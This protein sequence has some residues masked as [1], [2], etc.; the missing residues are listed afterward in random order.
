MEAG[1]QC[2]LDWL[3]LIWAGNRA[4]GGGR[5]ANVL[6]GSEAGREGASYRSPRPW[7]VLALSFRSFSLQ[8]PGAL[9]VPALG[10]RAGEG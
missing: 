4:G 9:C 8:R 10:I 1:G 3:N 7:F 2:S 6:V 5:E